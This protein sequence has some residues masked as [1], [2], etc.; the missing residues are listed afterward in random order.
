MDLPGNVAATA[1][2]IATQVATD[3]TSTFPPATHTAL[4]NNTPIESIENTSTPLDECLV[5]S[6]MK[7]DT[8]F[9]VNT[10]L[11]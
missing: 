11:N 3:I 1:S 9:K 5:C 10:L 7:R 6:D 2:P 8:I 4:N